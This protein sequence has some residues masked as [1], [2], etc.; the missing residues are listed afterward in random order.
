VR[1][2]QPWHE[3]LNVACAV[4]IIST[5]EFKFDS[6][7]QIPGHRKFNLISIPFPRCQV[8]VRLPGRRSAEVRLEDKVRL[9]ANFQPATFNRSDLG[10]WILGFRLYFRARGI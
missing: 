5:S 7:R 8:E 10:L 3:P 4:P 2:N 9:S 6:I 1:F